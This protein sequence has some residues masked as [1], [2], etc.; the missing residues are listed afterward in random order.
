MIRSYIAK[1]VTRDDAIK[2]AW[3]LV[4]AGMCVMSIEHT[5]VH[6]TEQSPDGWTDQ[7]FVPGYIIVVD[8][9]GSINTRLP[10]IKEKLPE[11][12]TTDD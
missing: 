9:E 7:G 3:S 10:E 12:P 5:M 1:D 11:L 4:S 8:T 6:W 2:K